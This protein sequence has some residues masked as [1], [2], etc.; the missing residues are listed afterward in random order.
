MKYFIDTH[1]HLF[2]DQF[3]SDRATMIARAAEVCNALLLPNIDEST[4][5]S[6][7]QMAETWPD[8]CYPTLGLHP[9]SV[10]PEPDEILNRLEAR[11][12]ER[13]WYGIG[14]TGI[15]LYWEKSTFPEQ[16][17]SFRRHCQW[18]KSARLP[19]IIH[20]RKA[21][22]ECIDI[23]RSEQDGNLKGVF[24]C[25]SGSE[26]EAERI[27]DCGFYMGIGGVITYPKTNLPEILQK[28][29]S[30]HFV[31]ETDSPYLPPV[32]YRGKRNESAYIRL[33]AEKCALA[34][35]ISMDQVAERTSLNAHTLFP[36]GKI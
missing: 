13:P 6:M 33:V 30:D 28:L 22:Q 27:I 12:G 16:A 2:S 7:L 11:L 23:I 26:T 18:A 25:F 17:K 21:T 3:D 1:T 29:G 19:I 14:E 35:G 32:P 8:L 15:D 10:P 34:W 4:I 9:S 31:L 5:P 24:H 36:L 20:S